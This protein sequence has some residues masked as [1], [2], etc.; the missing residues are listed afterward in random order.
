MRDDA[1]SL[2]SKEFRLWGIEF[3][4]RFRGSGHIELR[5]RAAQE[6]P[7]RSYIIAKTGSD[8]RGWLNAR[9]EIRRLL[10]AD[11]LVLK[12]QCVKK[13]PLL[14]KALELP[15]PEET[16][17]DQIKLLRAEIADLTDIVLEL[18]EKLAAMQAPAKTPAPDP[19]TTTVTDDKKP[20][21]HSIKAIDYLKDYWVS[22]FE[23][24]RDMGLTEDQTY[25]KLWYLKSKGEAELD[26]GRWRKRQSQ[27]MAA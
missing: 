9:A 16:E 1:L 23:L 6:K 21:V 4:H 24:A 25:G 7:V 11:G 15:R 10:R 3:D 19:V 27:Q 2:V 8:H 22:T 13:K 5:W 14:Q 26:H 20:T 18:S 12:E 17:L